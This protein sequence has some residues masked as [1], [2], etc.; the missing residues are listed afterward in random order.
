MLIEYKRIAFKAAINDYICT[1]LI[2]PRMQRVLFLLVLLSFAGGIHAQNIFLN[3]NDPSRKLAD[4]LQTLY[5]NVGDSIHTN[6]GFLSYRELAEVYRGMRG[7]VYLARLSNVDMY[8]I[9]RFL[10]EN[11]E[12]GKL[13]PEDF[14][15]TKLPSAW[16]GGYKNTAYLLEHTGGINFSLQPQVALGGM[17]GAEAEQV[18]YAAAGVDVKATVGARFGL[19]LNANYVLSSF[20]DFYEDFI[21]RRGAIPGTANYVEHPNNMYGYIWLN[22]H[23]SY[24]VVPEHVTLSAGYRQFFV[25]NGFRSLVLSDFAA[26][27][28]FA[29]FRANIW[30]LQYTAA[31]FSA[32][33][34]SQH[35][36]LPNFGENK[37]INFH[38]LSANVLPW[39]NV[40]LFETVTSAKNGGPEI[41]YFNPLI[42]Y[43][44][45][46]R[47]YGSPDKMAVGITAKAL[48]S[49]RAQLYGQFFLN[50]FTA[51][52]FFSGNGYKHNKW[53]AQIGAKYF[54][55]FEISNLDAQV[56][57]NFVRPYSY[58]HRTAANYSHNNLPLAH[59]LGAG[60]KE[61]LARVSY[62][63]N[64]RWHID[65]SA[66]MWQ[67]GLDSVATVNYGSDILKDIRNTV[68]NY[69]VSM[70]HGSPASTQIFKV[71]VG[72]EIFPRFFAE[73]GGA[74]RRQQSEITAFNS[75]HIYG[76]LGLRFHL[77][78]PDFFQF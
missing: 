58:Q 50:E 34:Q 22:G 28:P 19:N 25:G 59:P 18:I 32:T 12:Y 14:F 11:S 63:P 35:S 43:R 41:G 73:L 33:T 27:M 9:S 76:Y 45:I 4:R 5:G 44:S 31:F 26:P 56:E 62:R 61:V 46:E 53:G 6:T 69:G 30:K 54:N 13:T 15:N 38:L 42:F 48:L 1:L 66:M 68:G 37:F 57:A 49:K 78:R 52:E 36:G 74:Y 70:I 64:Y 23:A 60:F 77:A 40:G 51:K 29:S 67:Q 16:F 21:Q 39:L 55:L 65:A 8:E 24:D 72:Y 17:M 7:D 71:N 47:A 2:F 10:L 75:K 3:P 20:P